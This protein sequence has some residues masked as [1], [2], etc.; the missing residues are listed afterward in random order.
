MLGVEAEINSTTL[1]N[2]LTESSGTVY[3]ELDTTYINRYCTYP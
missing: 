2:I 3:A 1:I